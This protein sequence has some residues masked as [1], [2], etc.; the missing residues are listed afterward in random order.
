M[1]DG[2]QIKLKRE[3][4]RTLSKRVETARTNV[5]ARRKVLEA[6]QAKVGEPSEGMTVTPVVRERSQLAVRAIALYAQ[7]KG[8]L[9]ARAL[10]DRRGDVGHVRDLGDA[11]LFGSATAALAL[12][13]LTLDAITDEPGKQRAEGLAWL[14]VAIRLDGADT[15]TRER[16]KLMSAVSAFETARGFHVGRISGSS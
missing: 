1:A 8:V 2:Q 6:L 5:N 3:Y 14:R 15:E 16:A 13:D 12:A 11:A 4:L 9:A 7:K 10:R